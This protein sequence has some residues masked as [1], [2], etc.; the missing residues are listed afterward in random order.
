MFSFYI[1]LKAN[2]LGKIILKR[3]QKL[4]IS[5]NNLFFFSFPLLHN[6]SIIFNSRYFLSKIDIYF[7]IFF[8]FGIPGYW[9]K[10]ITDEWRLEKIHTCLL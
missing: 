3:I 4:R 5:I 9:I 1:E 7:S 8:L 10:N 2:L 6:S